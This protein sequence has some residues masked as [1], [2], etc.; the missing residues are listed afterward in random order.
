MNHPIG[1]LMGT[2]MD[3]IRQMMDVNTIIG[4]PI[5]TPDGVM[6]IPVSKVSLGFGSGGSDFSAKSSAAP[7]NFG[8]GGGAGVNITP[9]AF[10]VAKE[11]NVRILPITPPAS[12]SLDR[13][14]EQI[15]DVLEKISDFMDK[16][17]EKAAEKSDE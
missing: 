16:R 3:K 4:D 2:T 12:N 7:N 5:V 9:I 17:K 13:I 14:V 1:E 6:L 10:V 8:G 11:G 15:P